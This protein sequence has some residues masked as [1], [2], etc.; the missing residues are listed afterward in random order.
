MNPWATTNIM[1]WQDGLPHLPA[2]VFYKEAAHWV[3]SSS[4]TLDQATWPGQC[5]RLTAIPGHVRAVKWLADVFNLGLAHVGEFHHHAGR[6]C[7]GLV[8]A[9]GAQLLAAATPHP[10][11][12]ALEQIV[13]L[14]QQRLA[15]LSAHT[16]DYTRLIDGD[17]VRLTL[18][19][20]EADADVEF[21]ANYYKHLAKEKEL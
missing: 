7:F 14:A 21:M 2:A 1:F 5:P 4:S 19:L 15:R 13:A 18:P 20:L 3:V 10:E 8:A 9:L 11:G 17:S 12:K 6:Q 16:R